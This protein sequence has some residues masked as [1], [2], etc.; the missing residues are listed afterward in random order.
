MRIPDEIL[1]IQ[2]E[3]DYWQPVRAKYQKIWYSLIFEEIIF[4]A[5]SLGDRT[6]LP[7]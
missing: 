6:L 4:N 5:K 1:G 2:N 7:C 3:S